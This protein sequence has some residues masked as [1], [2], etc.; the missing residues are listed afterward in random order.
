MIVMQQDFSQFENEIKNIPFLWDVVLDASSK[1]EAM[2]L[3]LSDDDNINSS[4]DNNINNHISSSDKRNNN[5]KH[6]YSILDIFSG[7][8]NIDLNDNKK[9]NTNIINKP[10]SSPSFSFF[11]SCTLPIPRRKSNISSSES[12]VPSSSFSSTTPPSLNQNS[13]FFK[14]MNPLLRKK[15]MNEN[16]N[17]QSIVNGREFILPLEVVKSKFK[18]MT[19]GIC[20]DYFLFMKELHFMCSEREMKYFLSD[21]LDDINNKSSSGFHYIEDPGDFKIKK[22]FFPENKFFYFQQFCLRK[23]KTQIIWVNVVRNYVQRDLRMKTKL[24]CII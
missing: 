8:K 22:M 12:S 24:S 14:I 11:P 10:K 2:G 17:I 21:A 6:S 15:N 13:T 5:L 19:I 18:S 23:S 3:L 4:S 9:I 7:N 16:Q 1:G 20:P